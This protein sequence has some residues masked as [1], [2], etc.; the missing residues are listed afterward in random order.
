MWHSEARGKSAVSRITQLPLN[1]WSGY[2]SCR[3][4]R[5]RVMPLYAYYY[6]G[7]HEYSK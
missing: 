7:L 4:L 2:Q 5:W 3:V 1:Y 6:R